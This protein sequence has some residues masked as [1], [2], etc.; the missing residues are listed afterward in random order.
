MITYQLDPNSELLKQYSLPLRGTWKTMPAHLL[1]D[2]VL[3]DSNNVSIIDGRL[4]AR[5]GLKLFGTFETDPFDAS[6]IGSFLFISGDGTKYPLVSSPTKLY[7]LDSGTFTDI[8]DTVTL[9]SG[10]EQVRMTSIQDGTSVYL[11]YANGKDELKFKT[12]DGDLSDITAHAGS[13]PVCTDICTTFSRIVGVT[14][15]YTVQWCDVLNDTYL[16][17]TNWPALNQV[18]L[19]DTE[20]AIVAIRALGTLGFVVYKEGNIFA[21]IA[22]GGAPSQ[23]FRFEHRGEYEGPAGVQSIVNVTGLHVYFTRTGRVGAFDGSQHQWVCDGLW[24]FLRDDID[25][26]YVQNSFGVYNYKTN[27]VTFWY[28]RAGDSGALKGMLIINLAMPQAGI[29]TNAYFK[30]ES[31]V[32][33]TNGLS[34]RL[35]DTGT[36]PFVFSTEAF[37]LD[38]DTF[39][40]DSV[41]FECFITSPLSRVTQPASITAKQKQAPDIVRPIFEFYASRDETRNVVNIT[42]LTSNQLETDGTFSESVPVDLSVIS[43]NEYIGF[44]ETG[45]FIGFD[46]RWASSALVE[47]KGCDVYVRRTQ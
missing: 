37:T 30:G 44:N 45:G 24:P 31:L 40:D 29:A 3:Q 36:Q 18:V 4:R 27:E 8:T 42:A 11:L 41:S 7:Q 35:F 38:K 28:P 17:F 9:D 47:Y 26:Q 1:P 19:S 16:S 6:A 43:P 12:D 23:A 33:V 46:A 5:P 2:D 32:S 21:G 15:P 39:L 34:V 25:P 13:I 22:Q 14:P 20:D 10:A